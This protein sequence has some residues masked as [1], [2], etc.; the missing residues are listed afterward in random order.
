MEVKTETNEKINHGKETEATC[1]AYE[2]ALMKGSWINL[3]WKLINEV[4]M[5]TFP[6]R[7]YS[8][9]HHFIF[10]KILF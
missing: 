5:L 4:C 10:D 9:Y 1:V 2:F 7:K 3:H 8:L 6:S